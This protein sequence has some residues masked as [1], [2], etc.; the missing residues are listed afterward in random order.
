MNIFRRPDYTSE[1][2]QFI[3]QLKKDNPNLEAQQRQGRA[4][5]WDKKV[6]T[7][8]ARAPNPRIF[9]ARA[10]TASAHST[11]NPS[12]RP[13]PALLVVRQAMAPGTSAKR[14]SSTDPN[15]VRSD[16]GC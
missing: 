2:T 11:E 6:A 9:G 13:A 10:A 5:L 4:L 1:A 12:A 16:T 8:S 3:R 14:K 15:G 7:A